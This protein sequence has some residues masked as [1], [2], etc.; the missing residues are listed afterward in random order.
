M[1]SSRKWFLCGFSWKCG[2]IIQK[3]LKFLGL[4]GFRTEMLQIGVNYVVKSYFFAI[5]EKNGGNSEFLLYEG[6]KSL[7][8]LKWCPEQAAH[9]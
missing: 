1:I 9:I 4:M 8:P 7:N 3:V 5:D 2:I 6:R